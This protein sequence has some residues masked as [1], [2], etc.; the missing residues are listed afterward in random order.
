M[1]ESDI[2]RSTQAT[3]IR[4]LPVKSSPPATTTSI[5]PVANS[6]PA[7]ALPSPTD[8][9]VCIATFDPSDAKA[10]NAPARIPRTI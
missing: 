5:S 10:M 4:Q 7:S 1:E 3:I 9:M 2:L 6:A 8:S